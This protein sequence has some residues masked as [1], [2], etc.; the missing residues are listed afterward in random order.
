MKKVGKVVK[1][2]AEKK[3][4]VVEVES[5]K[6]FAK[7]NDFFKKACLKASTE[8]TKRQASKFRRNIGKAFTH[9]KEV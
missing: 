9:I 3:E 6:S 5:N 8:P 2:K 4:V 1:V 7:T